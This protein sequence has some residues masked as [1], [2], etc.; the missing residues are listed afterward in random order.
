M[1]VPRE[2]QFVRKDKRICLSK[3]EPVGQNYFEQKKEIA[4]I[5]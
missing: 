3:K 4:L 2:L 5:A 1:Q